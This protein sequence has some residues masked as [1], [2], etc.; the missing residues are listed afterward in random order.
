MM[1]RLK[2]KAVMQAIGTL[3]FVVFLLTNVFGLLTHSVG[4]EMDQR[5]NMLGCLFMGETTM[6]QMNAFEHLSLWQNTFTTIL[7]MSTSAALF[8]ALAWFIF[9]RHGRHRLQGQI[10]SVQPLHTLRN[11]DISLGDYLR[12]A[13]SQGIL[14]PKIS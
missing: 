1:R 7:S 8:L 9:S 13:F 12:Q 4:M 3:V 5:G 14:H 10:L 11:P 2:P 6:C